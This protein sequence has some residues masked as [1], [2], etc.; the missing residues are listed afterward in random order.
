MSKEDVS[1]IEKL[2]DA[3]NYQMWKFQVQIL[4][5]AADSFEIVNGEYKL[6][7]ITDDKLKLNWKTKDA[8][9]QKIII[10]TV[11]RQALTHLLHCKT[12]CEMF[13]KLDAIFERNTEQQR[14]SLLHEFFAFSFNKDLDI[15][16]H[17]SSLEDLSHKLKS[18]KQDIS[19]EM[20]IS[21]VLA[22]L[23]NSYKHFVSAWESTAT[24]EKSLT[25][26]TARLILEEGRL[27]SG[28]GDESDQVAFKAFNSRKTNNKFY[29]NK[30]NNSYQPKSYQN[31]SNNA[32]YQNQYN[33]PRSNSNFQYPKCSFC[34]KTNHYEKN[35][36]FNKNSN[37]NRRK[38]NDN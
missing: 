35:C 29:N 17:I 10:T 26:L 28:N 3:N 33:N 2:K 1:N 13:K 23:P 6:A 21:K 11:D 8:K 20:L 27:K 36:F 4:F 9:A 37:Y 30:N 38:N 16:S 19:E 14:Y 25:N 15:S 34:H 5:K 18:I 31:Q 24:E 32:S 12:S 7:D 22:I